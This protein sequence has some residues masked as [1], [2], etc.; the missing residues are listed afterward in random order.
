MA[1]LKALVF[2]AY[3]TILDVH[4]V[5]VECDRVAPGRGAELSQTWRAKQLE[6]TWLLSLMERYEDFRSV[7]EAALG[8]ACE[9]LGVSLDPAQRRRL[10]DAYHRLAPYPDVVEALPGLASYR[11][12]VLSN[13]SPGIL[14]P[15]LQNA[16]LAQWLE[17][18]ISVDP[19]RVYKPSPRVYQLACSRLGLRADEIGFVSSNSFDVIGAKAFGMR[20]YWLNRGGV[21]PDPL[22]FAPDATMSRLTELAALLR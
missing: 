19:I 10:M 16:G 5:A 21:I 12:A 6:Y 15:A 8:Y 17:Q 1:D 11:L 13:G 20:V 22:G 9:R 4:S 7:T 18:I 2:D 3:G 14:E